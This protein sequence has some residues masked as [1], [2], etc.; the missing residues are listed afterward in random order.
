MVIET[1]CTNRFLPKSFRVFL[2]KNGAQCREGYWTGEKFMTQVMNACTCDIAEVKYP[3]NKH[4]LIYVFHQ[5][6]CHTTEYG[7]QSLLAKNIMVKDGGPRRVRDT[8]TVWAGN[9]QEMVLP[10]GSAK[11]LRTSTEAST[12]RG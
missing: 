9:V 1:G 11:G 12:T 5:S 2:R 6:S 4:T 8:C 3:H 7:D 10:D